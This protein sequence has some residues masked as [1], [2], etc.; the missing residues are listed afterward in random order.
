MLQGVEARPVAQMPGNRNPGHFRK[1]HMMHPQSS[2]QQ[3]PITFTEHLMKECPSSTQS[4]LS[5]G[6][7]RPHPQG[8]SGLPALPQRHCQAIAKGHRLGQCQDLLVLLTNSVPWPEM[9]MGMTRKE[10]S[11]WPVDDN[12]QAVRNP[13]CSA[14]SRVGATQWVSCKAESLLPGCA[15][16]PCPQMPL[17]LGGT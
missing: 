2:K 11:N 5:P 12:C 4:M 7:E 9:G 17:P 10:H 3:Q 16:L 6:T 13:R 14:W 8:G 1:S 15:L